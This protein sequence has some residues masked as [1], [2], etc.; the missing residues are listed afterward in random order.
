MSQAAGLTYEDS[1]G[2]ETRRRRI[3]A[4]SIEKARPASRVRK[5]FVSALV[6]SIFVAIGGGIA[7]AY[8]YNYYSTIVEARVRSGFWHSRGGVYAAP[9]K[10][11]VGAAASAES[12]AEILR[13]SG[14]VEGTGS[15]E[16]WNGGFTLSGNSLVVTA[17]S[18]VGSEAVPATIKFS[19][20]H[21]A[22]INL[23][24]E[25]QKEYSI[26]PEL[27]IGRTE[28]KRTGNEVLDFNEIPDNLKNAIIVAEDQR[29]FSHHGID[30]RGIF[31]ALIKNINGN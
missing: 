16:I 10:L 2:A 23:N 3:K 13:R 18:R 30:P 8:F 27:L 14:Y 29:F 15:D 7:F 12:I 24:G 1:L 26:E 31:R 25:A 19:N 22:S 17:S 11:R 5:V 9:Y 6:I 20:G 21:V 28:T 4:V